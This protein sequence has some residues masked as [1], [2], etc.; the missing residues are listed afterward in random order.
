MMMRSR[1]SMVLAAILLALPALRAADADDVI[2]R[3]EGDGRVQYHLV[4]GATAVIK[5]MGIRLTIPN[6]D[7][8][9]SKY[10]P[11]KAL[12][13]IVTP[14]KRGD[15]I[16][17]TYAMQNNVAMVS[18]LALY[19]MK[20]GE[21]LLNGFI[22]N[23]SYDKKEGKFDYQMVDVKK[24]DQLY[25]MVIPNK[26]D[27]TSGDMAPDP[28]L[29]AAASKLKPGDVVLIDSVAGQTHRQIKSIELYTEPV[30]GYFL[31]SKEE[32]SE[33]GQ[34][35]TSVEIEA[36]GKTIT[37]FVPG[38]LDGKK[39]V[40]DLKVLG[41]VKHLRPKSD[42]MFRASDDNGKTVLHAIA[43]SPKQAKHTNAETQPETKPA[44]AKMDKKDASDK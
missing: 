36:D 27:P 26:K 6:S 19:P 30:P 7:E 3:F 8:K 23:E 38:H 10:D 29:L 9:Q 33:N 16:K 15:Y 20:P 13:D 39:W 1:C 40:A 21:D 25:T 28:D 18:A 12:L 4:V 5:G 41:E 35:E 2:A 44:A 34:T 11:Q 24:F 31:K 22:F 37:A 42:V 43:M 14:L 17:V 32:K